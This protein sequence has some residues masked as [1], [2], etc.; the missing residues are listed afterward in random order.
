[1]TSYIRGGHSTPTNKEN[2]CL[3][4]SQVGEFAICPLFIADQI[5]IEFYNIHWDRSTKPM[6]L[7]SFTL[8][9][10][11]LDKMFFLKSHYILSQ[12]LIWINFQGHF[13]DLN[14]ASIAI[15]KRTGK[16]SADMLQ[17]SEVQDSYHETAEST[18]G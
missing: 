16:E 5:S 3:Y 10:Y 7:S 17:V 12:V 8:F 6:S 14:V 1:M 2:V 11:A 18:A 15:I 4:H 13:R 9:Y